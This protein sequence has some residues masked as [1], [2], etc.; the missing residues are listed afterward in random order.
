MQSKN[1]KL[2]T[3]TAAFAA[4]I[5]I[6][7]GFIFHIPAGNGYVHIGD[8]IIYLAA[9][10]LPFPFGIFAGAIGAGMADLLT[11][12][13]IY[14]IPTIIIKSI[15]ALCFYMVKNGDKIFN[16][17]AVMVSCLSGIVTIIGYYIAAVLLYGNPVAQLTVLPGNLIQAA[18]STGLFCILGFA[19]DKVKFKER[20][21]CQ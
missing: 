21:H 13:A 6:T 12:Y 7:T 8:G 19:L 14:I 18:S 10:V 9:S 5:C 15:N 3:F 1:V 2:Y 4:L 20:L 16:R 17:K 11:G